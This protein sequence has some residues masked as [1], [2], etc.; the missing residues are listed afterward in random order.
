[1]GGLDVRCKREQL[2]PRDETGRAT[3]SH[4]QGQLNA[5]NTGLVIAQG[6]QGRRCDAE[7][8]LTPSAQRQP[9][10][11]PAG[12][13]RGRGKSVRGLQPGSKSAARDDSASYGHPLEYSVV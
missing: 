2:H 7:L 6:E 3:H 9:A 10:G 1:M 8:G 13:W 11:R 12:A 5:I 4:L